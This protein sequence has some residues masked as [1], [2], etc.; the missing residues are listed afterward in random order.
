[1]NH[2]IAHCENSDCVKKD[3]CYR[4]QAHLEAKVY[5]L[6][7]VPYFL[8]EATDTDNCE[9]YWNINRR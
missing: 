8:P 3:S 4:Y 9:Y 7:Y 1:M 5:K 2:D 6:E